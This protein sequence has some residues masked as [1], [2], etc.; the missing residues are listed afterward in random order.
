MPTL[1]REIAREG[2]E[3]HAGEVR[4]FSHELA[5]AAEFFLGVVHTPCGHGAYRNHRERETKTECRDEG[6]AEGELLHLK[7]H[8]Q[9]GKSGGAGHEAAGQPEGDDLRGGYVAILETQADIRRVLGF[10][11]IFIFRAVA[12]M[13][14]MAVVVIMVMVMAVIVRVMVVVRMTVIMSV[15]VLTEFCGVDV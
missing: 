10:V 4:R 14:M 12:M 6:E 7:T 2:D 8:E 1:P 3:D 9:D 5:E 11:S 15:G 13:M